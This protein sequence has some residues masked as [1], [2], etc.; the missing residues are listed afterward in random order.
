MFDFLQKQL[1]SKIDFA[2]KLVRLLKI[3]DLPDLYRTVVILMM[4][5]A[6]LIGSV[7]FLALEDEA[8][9]ERILVFC[10]AC[11]VITIYLLFSRRPPPTKDG[12]AE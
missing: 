6:G 8:R 1:Q 3:G 9:I 12:D 2:L 5:V 11:Y 7:L 10:M 4:V